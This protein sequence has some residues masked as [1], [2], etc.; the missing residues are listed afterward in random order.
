MP[1]PSRKQA[2]RDALVVLYQREITHEE[3]A[4]LL[5]KL[6]LREGYV[7]DPFTVDAVQGVVASQEALDAVLS[8][9]TRDWP[10]SRLAP[11]ERSALRL[12]LY[13]LEQGVT[14]PQ[15]VLDEAVRL[16]RRYASDEAGALINGIL[17]ACL[18]DREAIREGQ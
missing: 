10:L 1:T 8:S 14:P 17:G 12:G 16:V 11:L 4:E 9:Y 5:R 15:V 13:E 3:P 7:A 6:R 2:R 18:R